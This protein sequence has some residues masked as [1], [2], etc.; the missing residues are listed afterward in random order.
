MGLS[1]Q[2][3]LACYKGIRQRDGCLQRVDACSVLILPFHSNH[4]FR[5]SSGFTY[6]YIQPSSFCD[7]IMSH[8]LGVHQPVVV[9]YNDKGS[10]FYTFYGNNHILNLQLFG[11]NNSYWHKMI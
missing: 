8:C 9:F 6:T 11:Q 3:V 4:I 7:V 10:L 2:G 5:S 1:R